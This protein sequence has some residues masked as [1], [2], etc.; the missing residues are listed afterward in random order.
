[1]HR[2]PAEGHIVGQLSNIPALYGSGREGLVEVKSIGPSVKFPEDGL[3]K[4]IL[5][6]SFAGK[7]LRV[8]CQARKAS[9]RD[10]CKA[11]HGSPH[12]QRTLSASCSHYRRS[13]AK[14]LAKST[15]T[16]VNRWVAGA[17]AVEDFSGYQEMPDKAIAIGKPM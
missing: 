4:G 17:N 12:H 11:E 7:A 10:G 8:Q 1:M 14:I 9:V 6:L 16:A 3:H 13:A 15:N 5:E 2:L